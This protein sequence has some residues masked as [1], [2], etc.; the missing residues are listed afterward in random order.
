MRLL[1]LGKGELAEGRGVAG[2]SG[3]ICPLFTS[4][5]HP[6]LYLDVTYRTQASQATQ[7]CAVSDGEE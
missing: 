5:S 1:L 6:H 4:S 3:L 7:D 2:S